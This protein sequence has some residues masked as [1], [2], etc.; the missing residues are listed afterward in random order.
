MASS[1]RPLYSA[2]LGLMALSGLLG[3]AF[4]GEGSADFTSATVSR[5][6][7]EASCGPCGAS[8]LGLDSEFRVAAR[9][10][11]SAEL[12]EGVSFTWASCN[13]RAAS[14][15]GLILFAP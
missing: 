8:A 15:T 10:A 5:A 14:K 7:M 3:A 4:S 13:A 12:D 6:L 1:M 11:G 2:V 9:G